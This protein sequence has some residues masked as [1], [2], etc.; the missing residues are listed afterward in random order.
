MADKSIGELIPGAFD[1]ANAL[2]QDL[3][4][5]EAE[6]ERDHTNQFWRRMLVRCAV[7]LIEGHSYAMRRVAREILG[8]RDSINMTQ[9]HFLSDDSF[10]LSDTG[11]IEPSRLRIRF[12]VHVAFTFRALA[13]ATGA[14]PTDFFAGDGW[15]Q[16][17]A[18]LDVRNRLTHPKIA[19]DMHVSE[20]DI[21]NIQAALRWFCD[22][23]YH[24]FST[25]TTPS[26][27]DLPPPPWHERAEP[28]PSS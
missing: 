2:S 19:S 10:R 8:T 27:T 6:L 13:D 4:R 12:S 11:E 3:D 21:G 14:Q 1:A 20:N 23:H 25:A 15:R 18:A 16:F 22:C 17:K 5:C 9:Y 7:S 24:I 26:K 28:P